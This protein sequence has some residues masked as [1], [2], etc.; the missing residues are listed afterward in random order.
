VPPRPRVRF[1]SAAHGS[2]ALDQP[3]DVLDATRRAFV[4]LPWTWLQQVHG[5]TVVVV[6]G[7]GDRAGATADAA[8]TATPGAALAVYT[9]DCAPVAFT[10]DTVVGIAHAGWR[11]LVGGVLQAT[12]EAM[13]ELG[14]QRIEAHLGPCIRSRCYE[15]GAADL[16]AATVRLG[17]NVVASTAWGTQALDLT[18]GVRAALA[19][20]HVAT[21][22]DSGVCTACS[23]VHYSHRAR[24]D[25]ARLAGVV[26]L[27]P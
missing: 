17:P 3:A 6:D 14:A 19:Q 12:V 18:A 20:A 11:G 22:F 24:A 21:L 15:F 26:W 8:V 7:P 10:S 13:R 2:F 27:E 9:A 5:P 25:V 23:P 4:D 1:S 16:E